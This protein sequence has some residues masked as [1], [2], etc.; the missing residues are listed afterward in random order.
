MQNVF[1]VIQVLIVNALSGMHC[2]FFFAIMSVY[3]CHPHNALLQ[4]RPSD[5]ITETAKMI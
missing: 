3:I 1:F 4:S 5:H 2:L